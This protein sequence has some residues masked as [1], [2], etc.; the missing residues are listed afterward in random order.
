MSGFYAVLLREYWFFRSRFWQFTTSAMI[1]PILYL[2]AFGW[3]LGKVVQMEGISYFN[4]IIP[5][6][7][8][9]STMNA[10]FNAVATP[11]SIA[12]LYDKTYEEYITAPIRVWS[13]A[14][15]K[16]IA[17]ALRGTYSAAILL[18]L[19]VLLRAEV[20][21]TAGFVLLLFL[22]S[23]VFASLG[24]L[25]AMKIRSHPDMTRFTSYFITPMSFLCG[26]F[27]S[28]DSVPAL[29]KHLIN[30]LPLTYA[31]LGLR[32]IALGNDFPWH[33]PVVQL[34]FLA[35]FWVLGTRACYRVEQS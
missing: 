2:I 19:T 18:T 26:T 8:A 13:Y 24:F 16:I 28:V 7:V 34:A 25:A 32:A 9:L 17:G 10:S 35:A 6:I 23:L 20:H 5:G 3:G 4:F 21:I 11:T 14:A 31:S 12:R 30:L 15:G 27:F 22:N 1:S 29:A 33:A